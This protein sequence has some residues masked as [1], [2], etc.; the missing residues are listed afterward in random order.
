LDRGES[1][2]SSDTHAAV[3]SEKASESVDVMRERRERSVEKREK[4]GR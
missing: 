2:S 4:R 3:E 1:S